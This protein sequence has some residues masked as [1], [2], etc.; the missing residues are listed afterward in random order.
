MF[1]SVTDPEVPR[2][3]CS[4]AWQTW[5]SSDG[6]C[7]TPAPPRRHIQVQTLLAV[8]LSLALQSDPR[9]RLNN[10]IKEAHLDNARTAL[11]QLSTADSAR[12]A[13]AIIA[14]FPKVRDRID[15]LHR[16][17][18]RARADYDRV[19]TGITIT[20]EEKKEREKAIEA[21]A[22]RIKEANQLAIDG[23][24]MYDALRATLAALGP[25]AVPIIAAAIADSGSWN[26]KCELLEGLGGM[27][28]D[29]ALLAAL[30]REK[31]PVVIATALRG[32]SSPRAIPFLSHANWQV[33][34]SALIACAKQRDAVGPIIAQLSAAD[35]RFNKSAFDI[36]CAMTATRLPAD[37]VAWKD[38][39][40]ANR[41]DWEADRYRPESPKVLPGANTT[42]YGVPITSSRLCFIIDRSRSMKDQDRFGTAKTE[43][44]TLVRELPDTARV[45]I[46]CFGET[47]SCFSFGTRLLDKRGRNDAA[48][49]IDKQTYEEGTNLYLAIERS[50]AFVGSCETGTLREDG[51]DSL[52]IL[53][54]GESTVGRVVNDELIARVV[55][56]RARFLMPIIHAVSIGREA[57]SLKLMAKLN[58]GEYRTK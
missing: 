42:F 46:I 14:S 30:D 3:F 7:F 23:E 6:F 37:P 52:I 1:A 21:A 38:W 41:E 28:A 22:V 53:S 15:A 50:L 51:P 58:G 44:K 13:R 8:G 10:A 26:L 17:V 20:A 24:K 25:E 11:I 32:L 45:N 19:E 43:L 35:G 34:L 57:D 12:A 55:A 18:L 9:D 29:E 5:R 27:K 2:N 47:T 39:W 48:Y 56:R 36:L 16:G 33:R 49:F 40:K 4:P 54:D 31:E